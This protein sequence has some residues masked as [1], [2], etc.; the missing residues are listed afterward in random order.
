[1]LQG[2]EL[3]SVVFDGVEVLPKGCELVNFFCE[4]VGQKDDVERSKVLGGDTSFKRPSRRSNFARE[5]RG[6]GTIA[7]ISV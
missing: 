5:L 1:M 6:T 3:L 4:M 7:V 2:V